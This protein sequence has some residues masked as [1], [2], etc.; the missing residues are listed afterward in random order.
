MNISVIAVGNLYQTIPE[1]KK[2]FGEQFLQNE[3]SSPSAVIKSVEDKIKSEI[4]RFIQIG[5]ELERMFASKK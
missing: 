2:I 5:K 4:N 1:F 3:G